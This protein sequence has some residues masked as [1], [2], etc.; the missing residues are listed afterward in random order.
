MVLQ[1]MVGVVLLI[2]CTN[3]ANLLLAR[4]AARQREIA[5]RV[6]LGASRGQVVRQLFI[7][8]MILAV[9]GGATGLVLS[10]WLTRGLVRFLPYDP[11]PSRCLP[12]RIP[13][14]FSSRPRSRW[15]RRSSSG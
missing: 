13:A 6:A 8:S 12:R 2:A 4:S 11:R 3:V 10:I 14:C 5:I 9:A 1:W 7:E 15:L